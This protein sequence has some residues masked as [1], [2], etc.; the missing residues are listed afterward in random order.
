MIMFL[1][2]FIRNFW[3]KKQSSLLSI[4][5]LSIGIA[6][7]LVIG[8]WCV[9]EFSFDN[10]H[11]DGDSMYR[12]CKEG[13]INNE[14]IKTGSS[15]GAL[16]QTAKGGF[17]SIEESIR[18]VPMGEQDVE[19]NQIKS[20]DI[21]FL[22]DSNFFNF[23][24]FGFVGKEVKQCL[25]SPT[26]MVITEDVEHKYFPNGNSIGQIVRCNNKDFT[27]SAV[28]KNLPSNSHLQFDILVPIASDSKM[29]KYGWNNG[30]MFL[31]YLKLNKHTDIN[32]LAKK[33]T[34]LA[35]ENN[36][37]LKE[38]SIHYV[39]QPLSQIHFDTANF[40]FDDVKKGDKRFT[41]ILAFM[42]LAILSIACV[43]FTN[44]FIS[45]S[46]LRAKSVA[47]KKS[48]GAN[49]SSLIIEI[50]SET[51]LYV[52]LSL[53]LGIVL[54]IVAIPIFNQL[55]NSNIAFN[56]LDINLYLFLGSI[57]IV[58]TLFAGTFPAIYLSRIKI[59]S[60]LKGKNRTNGTLG[61]Q[62]VLV[63]MQFAASIVLLVTMIS[64]KKQIYFVQHTDLGFNKEN[65]VYTKAG[66]YFSKHY[67]TIK[68]ELEK[69][70]YIKEVTVKNCLPNDW[71]TSNAVE[72]PGSGMEPYIME[73]CKAK[74]NYFDV[75]EMPLLEG[76][77]FNDKQENS[78]G[79][80][81]NQKAAK[82]LQ[83]EN[84][85]GQELSIDGK[86]VIIKGIIADAK[87]KSLHSKI[88][89]QVYLPIKKVYAFNT[90]FIKTTG[91]QQEA[92]KAIKK[93]WS[94]TNTNADFEYHFLDKTYDELY[95]K[96][97][98]AGKMIT[99]G[100]VIALF[101]TTIGLVAMANYATQRRVKEIGVRKVN[102]AKSLELVWMLVKSFLLW[103]VI[104]LVIASPISFFI[105]KGWLSNF[106]Y[107]T[108]LSWWIFALSG[109]FTLVIAIV[110]VSWQSWRAA[111]RN[112]V[113]ALR[114]E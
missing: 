95:Q 30:D 48:N 39:L 61:F 71:Q 70:P 51:T 17:P 7:T 41:I 58:T 47:I 52:L 6:T 44:L 68:Q 89:P 42:V 91:N 16:S 33:M 40:R 53:A 110:T 22:A 79:T 35:Q 105:A 14:S 102:G 29:R 86:I 45:T 84:P 15:S 26:S 55:A 67:N 36:E 12:V 56:F 96:E 46:F 100:M 13:F 72:V 11:K 98:R 65:I 85:I 63:I 31:T 75:F 88:D 113:E 77:P 21:V 24:S 19:V 83:L 99:W 107:K 5:G 78:N 18:L 81:I 114:Y 62:K 4:G 108:E 54:A 111:T 32:D 109:I 2:Q 92:I 59:I 90:I 1:K 60:T 64:M 80:W 74:G 82:I 73:E 34:L 50:L 20:Q 57:G 8:W 103:V 112:P 66:K 37:F 93:Q 49:K 25:S 3:N 28:I 94:A 69:S 106:A 87:T 10:F 23:F 9:N 38:L 104:A 76:E 27:V 43:N 97:M 101:I